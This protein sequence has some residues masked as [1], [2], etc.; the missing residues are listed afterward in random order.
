M[1]ILIV[2]DTGGGKTSLGVNFGIK[3][4]DRGKEDIESSMCK[5]EG[6]SG[7]KKIKIPDDHLVYSDMFF[8]GSENSNKEN[9]VNFT[10]GY[11]FGLPN[12]DFETDYFVYGS[13]LI[14]D[15]SRKYWSARKSML[16][17]DKGGT[18]PKTLEAFELHRH[19]G[20]TII[21]ISQLINHLDINIRSLAHL[22]INP[23]EILQE[24]VGSKLKRIITKWKCR[25][26]KSA[27][28]YEFYI[29]GDKTVK[30]ED[31]EYIFNGD[32]FD[33]Y[34]S[35]FFMFQFLHGLKKYGCVKMKPCDGTRASVKKMYEMY[36]D[37]RTNY[38]AKLDK[39]K[40]DSIQRF[41]KPDI[42][43]L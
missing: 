41:R 25:Q 10:T 37:L 5:L 6:F 35:E 3:A 32:I 18:H 38:K 30:F 4:M 1:I 17:Y 28:D 21:L 20:L 26:F 15:E 27:E 36:S 7:F 31:V 23:Y 19:N 24:K 16:S 33:C 12:S 42:E 39:V 8:H 40:H 13:T 22:V 34:D 2:G 29:K 14:F 9:V 11:R 43:Y